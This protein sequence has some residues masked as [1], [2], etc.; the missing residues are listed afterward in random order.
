M[1][2]EN[3]DLMFN[4]VSEMSG[5]HHTLLGDIP[6]QV[7]FGE[8][9]STMDEEAE[10]TDTGE[11]FEHL[12]VNDVKNEEGTGTDSNMASTS[13]AATRQ[14]ERKEHVN[15]KTES[16]ES[17]EMVNADDVLKHGAGFNDTI[18]STGSSSESAS[19]AGNVTLEDIEAWLI[20]TDGI[21]SET[22]MADYPLDNNNLQ[23]SYNPLYSAKPGAEDRSTEI[24][25]L[26]LTESGCCRQDSGSS[27]MS[28]ESNGIIVHDDELSD[29]VDYDELPSAEEVPT[30]QSVAENDFNDQVGQRENPCHPAN[31]R[32]LYRSRPVQYLNNDSDKASII[33]ES[34]GDHFTDTAEDSETELLDREVRSVLMRQQCVDKGSSDVEPSCLSNGN[35]G[36]TSV[37]EKEQQVSKSPVLSKISPSQECFGENVSTPPT[38]SQSSANPAN[39]SIEAEAPTNSNIDKSNVSIS[40][41]HI[42]MHKVQHTNTSDENVGDSYSIEGDTHGYDEKSEDLLQ[43]CCTKSISDKKTFS[44]SHEIAVAFAPKKQTDVLPAITM[45]VDAA[46]MTPALRPH[47]QSRGRSLTSSI[48]DDTTTKHVTIVTMNNTASD[49]KSDVSIDSHDQGKHKLTKSVTFDSSRAVKEPAP[50]AHEEDTSDV[51]ASSRMR[52]LSDSE[53]VSVR[54][55]TLLSVLTAFNPEDNDPRPIDDRGKRIGTDAVITIQQVQPSP[56]GLHLISITEEKPRQDMTETDINYDGNVAHKLP[57]VILTHVG[58]SEAKL[59]CGEQTRQSDCRLTSN[60]D[61]KSLSIKMKKLENVQPSPIFSHPSQNLAKPIESNSFTVVENY[62]G[63]GLEVSPDNAAQY[64]GKTSG[65]QV[66]NITPSSA[67]SHAG[68]HGERYTAASSAQGDAHENTP[69]KPADC[70]VIATRTSTTIS[71][72]TVHPLN[73]ESRSQGAYCSGGVDNIHTYTLCVSDADVSS[74]THEVARPIIEDDAIQFNSQGWPGITLQTDSMENINKLDDPDLTH[75][76]RAQYGSADREDKGITVSI[77]SDLNVSK[78]HPVEND[79]IDADIIRMSSSTFVDH[80]KD[81]SKERTQGQDMSQCQTHTLDALPPAGP[82]A[83]LNT[84]VTETWVNNQVAVTSQLEAP[85]FDA[86]EAEI[87]TQAASGVPSISS[88]SSP[89]RPRDIK[90]ERALKQIMKSCNPQAGQVSDDLVL[91]AMRKLKMVGILYNYYAC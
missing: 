35:P 54:D 39:K 43:Y 2:S 91:E 3:T 41:Q 5:L 27:G 73:A 51:I 29:D 75:S 19:D 65:S 81:Q 17:F 52:H 26:Q 55:H 1:A 21:E 74:S 64:Y 48:D 8:S 59:V 67:Q 10:G 33:P 22:E 69:Q 14:S 13:D 88:S 53:T 78:S 83:H 84:N 7:F 47:Q 70:V 18:D 82:Q 40:P 72:Q 15:D 61:D 34:I 79:D 44:N 60:S 56:A 36:G 62:S 6:T 16:C 23:C 28:C 4:I 85:D 25:E 63:T 9:G 37:T 30:L 58:D 31:L 20:E 42:D 49:D 90:Q 32:A 87:S 80:S 38:H 45:I 12:S 68:I 89:R 77:V 46:Q 86:I 50:L 57:R 76:S 71:R 24:L 11:D 66:N